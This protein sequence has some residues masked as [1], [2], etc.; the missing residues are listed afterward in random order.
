MIWTTM[1][2]PC[3]LLLFVAICQVDNDITSWTVTV[4]TYTRQQSFRIALLVSLSPCVLSLCVPLNWIVAQNCVHRIELCCAELNCVV[5][6]WRQIVSKVLFA[7]R[8]CRYHSGL[9]KG[10]HHSTICN[11]T[12]CD[13][14]CLVLGFE[15]DNCIARTATYRRE[16]RAPG[17]IHQ[18]AC[19][20]E[21]NNAILQLHINT[22]CILLKFPVHLHY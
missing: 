8:Q 15:F 7:L 21:Y 2:C 10:T 11:V 22:H 17:P 16:S 14:V 5:Q 4:Y 19:L 12:E 13:I 1:R 3:Q 9:S 20:L 18:I 6:L